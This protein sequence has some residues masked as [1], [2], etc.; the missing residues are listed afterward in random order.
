MTLRNLYIKSCL[1]LA[2]VSGMLLVPRFAVA[3]SAKYDPSKVEQMSSGTFFNTVISKQNINSDDAV[4]YI[5]CGD[6]ACRADTQKCVVKARTQRSFGTFVADTASLVPGGAI[7]NGIVMAARGR[8]YITKYEYKCIDKNAAVEDGWQEN[9]DGAYVNKVVVRTG[10]LLQGFSEKTTSC[11]TGN[12]GKEYCIAASSKKATMDKAT[13][14]YNTANTGFKGCE[15]LPVKLYNARKCFFCPL[16]SVMYKVAGEITALSFEKLAAAFAVILILGWAIWIAVQTLTQVSSL[17][18][19]DAPKFLTN[20]I[21][22]SYKV[23]IAFLLLQ[24]STQI[25]ELA[26]TPVLKAGLSFG[27][28]MLDERYSVIRSSEDLTDDQKREDRNPGITKR[29]AMLTNTTYY[30]GD[31]YLDLDNFV[32]NIQR[33]ISFMQG[34]GTSLICIGGHGMITPRS[35][36][37]FG[38][39]FMMAVQGVILSAFAFLL[40]IAFAFYLVD[41]VVQLGLAGVLMPF[42]IA[43][44]PF[45]ITAKYTKVGWNMIL[46]S[47]FIFMFA[48]MVITVDLNLVSAAVNFTA[49]EQ[50]D[51]LQDDSCQDAEN[52]EVKMGSLYAIAK[53]INTQNETELVDLTDISGVG[54]LILLFCCIFGFQFM[55]RTKDMAGTFA[56]GAL[57]PIAP[58]IAT[59]GASAAKS[60]ALKTTQSTRDAIGRHVRGAPKQLWGKIRGAFAGGEDGAAGGAGGQ[61]IGNGAGSGSGGGSGGESEDDAD[62]NSSPMEVNESSGS[63]VPHSVPVQQNHGAQPHKLNEGGNGTP[64]QNA[65]VGKRPNEKAGPQ[66]QNA[67]GAESGSDEQQTGGKAPSVLEQVLKA[68]KRAAKGKP[69]RGS[70]KARSR[71]MKKRRQNRKH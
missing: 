67:Q 4:E 70:R 40:A 37:S 46:N 51:T 56:S 49:N 32:V 42:L 19:Q 44:W 20:L 15:V 61:P 25:F 28:A 14:T 11:Y 45:K 31:L 60:F 48:G 2:L 68:G 33:N 41:A 8:K 1:F 34:V 59:M 29:L 38:A 36:I 43:S 52:C 69:K 6:N 30:S 54:F 9:A 66:V 16:F 23:L 24:Y 7:T 47:A 50:N 58:S 18:K 64:T 35:T 13:I 3:Q 22:Q 63:G 65:P 27:N 17:T 71:Q 53:A 12:D 5:I 39:G 55:G 21:K 10:G 57:K 62:D 26:I